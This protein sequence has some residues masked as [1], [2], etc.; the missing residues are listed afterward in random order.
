MRKNVLNRYAQTDDGKIIIDVSTPKVESLY[1]DFDKRAPYQRKELDQDLVDYLID[2]A[3]EICPAPFIIRISLNHIPDEDIIARVRK[4]IE[5]YFIYLRDY[6]NRRMKDM[7][8]TSFIL[9]CMGLCILTISIWL[10]RNPERK[11][12]PGEI[13]TE[14]LTVAAWVSLWEALATFL[15]QWKPYRKAIGIYRRLGNARV[16]FQKTETK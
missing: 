7:A 10:G 5:N 9:L 11:S 15:I 8:R 4:S 1:N 3:E 2:S 6:D 12:M 16:I 13:F 14:G